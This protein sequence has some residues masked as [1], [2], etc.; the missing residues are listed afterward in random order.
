MVTNN[1]SFEEQLQRLLAEALSE[2]KSLEEK[3]G[4]LEHEIGIIRGEARGYE[5]AL[6]GYRKRSGKQAI[7]VQP[8]WRKLLESQETHKDKLVA[9]ANVSDGIVKVSSAS[10]LLYTLGFIKSKRRANAY[11]IIQT[12]LTRLVEENTFKK[13]GPGEYRLLGAQESLPTL[14]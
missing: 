3:R 14:S 10:D 13:V 6:E 2:L 1:H 11:R 5:L 8:N 7:S 12:L 9:I 4:E